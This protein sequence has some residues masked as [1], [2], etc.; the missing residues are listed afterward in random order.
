MKQLSH[1]FEL[2]H[3]S[4]VLKAVAEGDV[5]ALAASG[6]KL[7]AEAQ[8]SSKRQQSSSEWC[9]AGAHLSAAS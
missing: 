6:L 3:L 7:V 9:I 2:K 5:I 4:V 1:G 8:S